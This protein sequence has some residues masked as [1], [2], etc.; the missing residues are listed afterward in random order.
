M[1]SN[2]V[3]EKRPVVVCICGT[4]KANR[5]DYEATCERE[6]LGGRIVLAPGYIHEKADS[7]VKTA[8]E[9]L[10]KRRIDMCDQVL[11]IT[12]KG[13]VSVDALGEVAY[14]KAAGKT[15]VFF[16]PPPRTRAL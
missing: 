4:T 11:V 7:G 12:K 9:E 6:A 15:I 8:L 1:A 16:E 5:A 3:T 2:Q 14:A 10:Q 13:Q